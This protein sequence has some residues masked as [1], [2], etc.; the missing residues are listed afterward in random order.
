M[1]FRRFFLFGVDL[2]TK[3]LEAHHSKLS[4]YYDKS[5]KLQSIKTRFEKT[6]EGNFGGKVYTN[7]VFF[8]TKR[9]IESTIRGLNLEVYNTSDGVLIEGSIS[10][11]IED[12]AKRV[13]KDLNKDKII[14][15]VSLCFK[16]TYL[17]RMNLDRKLRELHE[18]MDKYV[19]ICEAELRNASGD[20]GDIVDKFSRIFFE[21][22]SLGLK[23]QTEGEYVLR[24]LVGQSLINMQR[25]V[26]SKAFSIRD[27]AER[28]SYIRTAYRV[29]RE[30]L[31]EAREELR[32]KIK[33]KN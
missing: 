26:L 23:R 4:R 32:N 12:V 8:E 5:S 3:R 16:D 2:G 19:E 21:I 29:I 20:L 6:C 30:F 13:Q 27:E 31:Q 24:N 15:N 28:T 22:I 10:L 1:G 7:L 17:R 11:R 33:P 18:D 9:S 14:R 25:I